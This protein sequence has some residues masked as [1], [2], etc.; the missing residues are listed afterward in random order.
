M[1]AIYLLKFVS[2]KFHTNTDHV[3]DLCYILLFY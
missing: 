3:T 2:E 1:L